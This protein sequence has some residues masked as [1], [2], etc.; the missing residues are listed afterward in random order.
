VL[1]VK[2]HCAE[3][4]AKKQFFAPQTDT[5]CAADAKLKMADKY[6][7]LVLFIDSNPLFNKMTETQKQLFLNAR[8]YFGMVLQDSSSYISGAKNSEVMD[9]IGSFELRIYEQIKLTPGRDFPQEL[10]ALTGLY[11]FVMEK[12]LAI[13][14]C[15]A[16]K[17]LTRFVPLFDQYDA[18]LN[19]QSEMSFAVMKVAIDPEDELLKV[20]TDTLTYRPDKSVS[21]VYLDG[22]RAELIAQ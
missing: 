12:F 8:E 20:V 11:R 15:Q 10:L 2:N 1:D 17:D 18:H 21:S 3:K 4:T 7:E 6:D 14:Q 5:T 13:I 16:E 19:P 22:Y 9:K